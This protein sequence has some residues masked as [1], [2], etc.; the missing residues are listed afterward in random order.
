MAAHDANN[1]LGSSLYYRLGIIIQ[2]GV[3]TQLVARLPT[4][5]TD[6]V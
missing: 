5:Q 3:G 2:K 1:N 4:L 6:P